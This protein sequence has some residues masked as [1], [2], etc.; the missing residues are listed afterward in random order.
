MLL[1]HHAYHVSY[2]IWR[3]FIIQNQVLRVTLHYLHAVMMTCLSLF[4]SGADLE[5]I[6]DD[7]EFCNVHLSECDSN[8]QSA[9]QALL[10]KNPNI[11]GKK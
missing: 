5:I 10:S 11:G 6:S 8:P 2:V 3:H 4:E 7:V 1:K 9:A